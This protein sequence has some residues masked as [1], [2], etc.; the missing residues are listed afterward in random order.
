MSQI[1]QNLPSV[2]HGETC[3]PLYFNE[4]FCLKQK[5]QNFK[6]VREDFWCSMARD[7]SRSPLHRELG[8]EERGLFKLLRKMDKTE[9]TVL[10]N[11]HVH[12][13]LYESTILL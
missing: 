1:L 8:K 9:Q 7:V 6:K 13:S 11:L 10:S 12:P 5:L 3:Q 2:T 4:S